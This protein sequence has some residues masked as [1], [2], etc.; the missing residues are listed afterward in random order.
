MRRQWRPQLLGYW[1]YAGGRTVLRA[2]GLIEWF[3][4]IAAA[5]AARWVYRAATDGSTPV[6]IHGHQMVLAPEH[7]YASPDMTADRYERDTTRLFER[8]VKPGQLVMD[9]GAHV[10]YYTLLSAKL[11]G[12][13]G[14]VYAF[15]PESKNYAL[16]QQNIARNGYQNVTAVNKAVADV[17]GAREL[18]LSG[19]DNGFHSLFQL[20]LRQAPDAQPTVIEAVTLDDFLEGL[21]WPRVDLIKM[22]IEGGE[23]TALEGMQQLLARQPSLN[24]IVEFCPWILE[25]LGVK[26]EHFI[27]RFVELGFRLQVIGREGTSAL[28]PQDAPKLIQRLLQSDGYANLFCQ[29]G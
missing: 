18:F 15:E 23:L 7:T 24:L 12:P 6:V 21:G 19:L 13:T 1:I 22:D 26:P 8:L 11:V 10:G 9:L 20:K 29:R 25:T 27:D 28:D 4:P 5:T 2:T 16:L 14:R 3:R 17:S